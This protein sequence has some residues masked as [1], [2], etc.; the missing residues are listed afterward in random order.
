[1]SDVL[2]LCPRC[3]EIMRIRE[4]VAAALDIPELLH[5]AGMTNWVPESPQ[6]RKFSRFEDAVDAL[7]EL[8]DFDPGDFACCA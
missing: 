7:E 3:E 4:L 5:D 1:M 8:D 6:A 2:E